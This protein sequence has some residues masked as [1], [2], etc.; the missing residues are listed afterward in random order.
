MKI[1]PQRADLFIFG[2]IWCSNLRSFREFFI[3]GIFVSGEPPKGNPFRSSGDF[4][5]FPIENRWCLL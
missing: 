1:L 4:V 2:G 3:F 5:T